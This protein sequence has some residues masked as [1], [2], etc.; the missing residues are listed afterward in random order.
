MI[1]ELDHHRYALISAG[2]TSRAARKDSLDRALSRLSLG[3]LE[4]QFR[5]D[6]SSS[7]F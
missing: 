3:Q 6:G 5:D 7:L 2:N 4:S 1:I